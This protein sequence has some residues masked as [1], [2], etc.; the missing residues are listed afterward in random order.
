M[1]QNSTEVLSRRRSLLK[2]QKIKAYRLLYEFTRSR[3]SDC[4]R[5][6]CACKDTICQHVQEQA[7]RQGVELA[8][9][10]HRLRFI[11]CGGCV[12]PPHLRET[13][14][15][16]LCRPSLEAPDFPARQYERLKTLC[17]RID[18]KLMLLED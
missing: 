16:Y 13:C 9:T 11:G 8:P 7:R 3:C 5:T 17:S 6:D 14:T 12:V 18:E 1:R 15:I 2:R 4:A 10:G